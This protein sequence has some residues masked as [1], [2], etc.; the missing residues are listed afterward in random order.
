MFLVVLLSSCTYQ[1]AHF[2]M[3]T[4]KNAAINFD[5]N[6]TVQVKGQSIK[7]LGIGA[8]IED[9]VDNAFEALTPD[10]DILI[11]AKISYSDTFLFN[12]YIVTANAFKSSDLKAWFGNEGY[13]NWCNYH[14][15]LQRGE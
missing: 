2:T 5:R 10:Y 7:F 1:I 15:L 11:D 6:K 3:L 12:G 9:A 8:S 4:T 13:Q 14:N